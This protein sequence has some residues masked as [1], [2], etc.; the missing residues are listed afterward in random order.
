MVILKEMKNYNK[1]RIEII[2]AKDVVTG[3]P[4][5]DF[6]PFLKK[7]WKKLVLKPKLFRLSSFPITEEKQTDKREQMK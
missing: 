5:T 4:E 6:I 3:S 2:G 7:N 1:P